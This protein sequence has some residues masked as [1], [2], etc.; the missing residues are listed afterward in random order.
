MFFSSQLINLGTVIFA[1]GVNMLLTNIGK[2]AV[3]RLRPHFIATC[4]HDYSYQNFCTHP[5]LWI[6]NYTCVGESDELFKG[7]NDA[8]DVRYVRRN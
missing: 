7:N 3:G 4:F 2:V 8:Y 1:I 6:V 5:N